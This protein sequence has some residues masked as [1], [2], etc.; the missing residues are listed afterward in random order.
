MWE[1]ES[2]WA[3]DHGRPTTLRGRPATYQGRPAT[4]SAQSALRPTQ[5][6]E[7]AARP[8]T[9]V[10]WPRDQSELSTCMQRST[11][12]AKCNRCIR[13]PMHPRVGRTSC[14]GSVMSAIQGSG[15]PTNESGRPTTLPTHFSR[16]PN[17]ITTTDSR[18][19][20]Q[21]LDGQR[22]QDEWPPDHP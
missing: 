5:P 10:A 8:L 16:A 22:R 3:Q 7:V 11:K 14:N 18:N 2:K 19:A 6:A 21:Q 4:W 20:Y 9:M 17:P 13:N 12:E 1:G 15:R